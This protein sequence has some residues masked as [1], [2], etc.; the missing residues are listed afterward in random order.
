M[1]IG[2]KMATDKKKV[3][4]SP[5]ISHKT[6]FFSK[7]AHEIELLKQVPESSHQT[8]SIGVSQHIGTLIVT[9]SAFLRIV[10][11]QEHS[12]SD[13]VC[14]FYLCSCTCTSDVMMMRVCVAAVQESQE[15][16]H[17]SLFINSLHCIA[18]VSLSFVY[19]LVYYLNYVAYYEG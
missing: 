5:K 2:A 8:G 3:R 15:C 19:F 17:S 13:S 11:I 10:R 1:E 6:H 16:Q 12:D 4:K 18:F 14:I 7:R 9:Q